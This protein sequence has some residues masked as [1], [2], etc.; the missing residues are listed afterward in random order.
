MFYTMFIFDFILFYCLVYF[1]PV[2]FYYCNILLIVVS[3]CVTFFNIGFTTWYTNKPNNNY[4]WIKQI[5]HSSRLC[6]LLFKWYLAWTPD[7]IFALWP[8]KAS[9]FT[10]WVWRKAYCKCRL[11]FQRGQQRYNRISGQEEEALSHRV[12]HTP[13]QT[14]CFPHPRAICKSIL[15]PGNGKWMLAERVERRQAWRSPAVQ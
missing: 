5:V 9:V 7:V 14:R 2:L 15:A 6:L 4:N 8:L 13:T 1:I 12:A 10:T 11:T 3:L